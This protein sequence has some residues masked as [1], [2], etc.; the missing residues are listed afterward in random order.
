MEYG[1]WFIDIVKRWS[2]VHFL[3]MHHLTVIGYDFYVQENRP[4]IR[5][6]TKHNQASI[7]VH[8]HGI[9]P[10][11]LVKVDTKEDHSGILTYLS[12][13][14][15]SVE[16]QLEDCIH[17]YLYV[18]GRDIYGYTTRWSL[19]LKL[20]LINPFMFSQ[21][22]DF[23]QKDY[24]LYHAHIPYL[25]QFALSYLNGEL[26]FTQCRYRNRTCPL[27]DCKCI[28]SH[29][30]PV[31][32]GFEIDVDESDLVIKSKERVHPQFERSTHEK[33]IPSLQIL[34]EEEK[35]RTGVE[36][37]PKPVEKRQWNVEGWDRVQERI[38]LLAESTVPEWDVPTFFESIRM[39]GIPLSLNPSQQSCSNTSAQDEY[40]H[41][42]CTLPDM[43]L[44]AEEM[45][46]TDFLEEES[47]REL[48]E[49]VRE[50]RDRSQCVPEP[51]T[52]VSGSKAPD[53]LP[54]SSYPDLDH[55]ELQIPGDA[56]EI[57]QSIAHVSHLGK[58][59]IPQWDG[60]M[61]RTWSTHSF[62]FKKRRL[63]ESVPPKAKKQRGTRSRRYKHKE[64]P[65][66]LD[67]KLE[68]DML[69]VVHCEPEWGMRMWS[70][71]CG[72]VV[73]TSPPRACSPTAPVP[74]V[75]DTPRRTSTPSKPVDTPVKS[76]QSIPFQ[77]PTPTEKVVS[78]QLTTPQ[79]PIKSAPFVTP[80]ATKR[81]LGLSV[82]PPIITDV[83]HPTPF[84]SNPRDRTSF[85]YAT[86]EFKFDEKELPFTGIAK[87]ME[88]WKNVFERR[89][90]SKM[91][92]GVGFPPPSLEELTER[93]EPRGIQLPTQPTGSASQH[94]HEHPFVMIAM[95]LFVETQQK[96][97]NPLQDPI[98]F[99][100]YHMTP[101]QQKGLFLRDP[102]FR[103][104]YQ[105]IRIHCYSSER[106]LI[107]AFL[108]FV[109]R[110]DPD[111]LNGYEIQSKSWGYL[112][113]RAKVYHL[114][115]LAM[116]SKLKTRGVGAL[117]DDYNAKKAS[118]L[119]STGRVFVNTWRVVR[120]AATLRMYTLHHAVYQVC[121]AR[122]PDFHPDVLST[123]YKRS[124]LFR[125]RVY[126]HL[127]E[128]TI[129]SVRLL[130]KLGILETNFQFSQIYGIDL[131]S[132]FTRGSQYRV[133]SILHRI[134]QPENYV[135]F[136]PSREHVR[137]MNAPECLPLNMEPDSGMYTPLTVLDFQSLYPSMMVA[138]NICYSTCLGRVETLGTDA[139]KLGCHPRY[140]ITKEEL[141][142]L[143]D[144]VHITPN[145][146]VFVRP[147]VRRGILPQMVTELM[148]SR[149]MLKR[150]LKVQWSGTVDR[151]QLA[152]KLLANVTFGY[153]AATFSGRMPCVDISDAIV[154]S[155]RTTLET[156]IR[157]IHEHWDGKVVYGD[158]DSL[159]VSF[160]TKHRDEAF[161][162][163]AKIVEAITFRN[164]TPVV[165]KFEKVYAPG[166]L[167]AK[168]RYVGFK[169][170]HPHDTPVFDAKG[171]ET[172][173]RDGCQATSKIM[174]NGLKILFRTNDLS[175]VKEYFYREWQAL[176]CGD[177]D[178]YDLVIAREVKMGTYKR[179]IVPG[180]YLA[181][182]A[183][184]EDEHAIV[185]Y[186][187]RVP[188]LVVHKGPKH[189]LVDQVVKPEEVMADPSLRVNTQYYITK[190]IIPPLCRVFQLVGADIQTWY[191]RMPKKSTF[192]ADMYQSCL[193]CSRSVKASLVCDECKEQPETVMGT[194]GTE[195]HWKQREWLALQR[196]CQQCTAMQDV[197]CTSYDCDVFYKRMKRSQE[198]RRIQDCLR[199][200]E[201]VEERAREQRVQDL[202]DSM[203]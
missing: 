185:H 119:V 43:I 169:Y 174:E 101:S 179:N 143:G 34:W 74:E 30:E 139:H 152:L 36:E 26:E 195:I 160:P 118:G 70:P 137:L 149:Q 175:Q 58:R 141:E 124:P 123:W 83:I 171:I 115:A 127:L 96:E 92:V 167:V 44:D 85:T 68:R 117:H 177:V 182:K 100:A 193:V 190:Q 147:H 172:V 67:T 109:K 140:L 134:T 184:E 86:K 94:A 106:E 180:A 33:L 81:I 198:A 9:F 154:Q 201:Q 4:I 7:L 10:Y 196:V 21:I 151:Q 47:D 95:E 128:R 45:H 129:W 188:F 28:K 82:R 161:E 27:G 56:D 203:M 40:D 192:R 53:K 66:E 25:L 24:V 114:N 89:K 153:T 162:L 138:Y 170:E 144:D 156:S 32:M 150:G 163:G 165:L 60:G 61:Q 87:G 97:P 159:F 135:H 3:P 130:S 99:L 181:S 73:S 71:E 145:G 41:F 65:L 194:L 59:H 155:G 189:R 23:L 11:L 199:A 116:I 112:H 131:Y 16:K 64:L 15:H 176:L 80:T 142:A 51:S 88:Y 133:E 120:K 52:M 31:S 197:E 90:R 42:N 38:G 132:V 173:R 104:T 22:V 20:Y 178:L 102:T 122:L 6:Y 166:I 79:T 121:G 164:P 98:S 1:F 14:L 125:W 107:E 50:F 186:G 62:P 113:Q 77:T 146:V 148:D 72:Q 157:Y 110:H 5:C 46:D 48:E 39:S 13:F 93:P 19:F 183:M 202:L 35:R 84:Y 54:L 57:D 8:V 2:S 78:W 37:V 111:L 105:G 49:M 12:N 55:T 108:D 18:Q 136:S 17:S 200:M 126:H 158:T 103:N 191:Q 187:D 29:H 75:M 76:M 63:E 91:I 69:R 168:K